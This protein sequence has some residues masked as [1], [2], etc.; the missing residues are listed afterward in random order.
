MLIHM[1][2]IAVILR[3]LSSFGDFSPYVNDKSSF[4]GVPVSVLAYEISELIDI[5]L[6]EA[7]G[8]I[9]EMVCDGIFSIAHRPG[10]PFYASLSS[11]GV[12]AWGMADV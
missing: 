12:I 10:M 1:N 8:L 11:K 6:L 7:E 3:N 9:L 4:P 5:S 2:C